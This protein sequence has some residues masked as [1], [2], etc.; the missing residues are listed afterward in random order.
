MATVAEY[1]LNNFLSPLQKFHSSTCIFKIILNHYYILN[2]SNKYSVE[3]CFLF[4][5][6]EFAYNP[7]FCLLAHNAWNIYCLA[8]YGKFANTCPTR[9]LV[10]F[11]QWSCIRSGPFPA[12]LVKDF[13]SPLSCGPLRLYDHAP[14][15]LSDLVLC[16][17]RHVSYCRTLAKLPLLPGNS[18]HLSSIVTSM[19]HHFLRLQTG[20]CHILLKPSFIAVIGF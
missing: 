19:G 5:Y 3:I 1:Q 9:Q 12:S 10:S 16:P 11:S 7:W 4:C 13:A 20:I 8:L 6:I 15:Y 18:A 2:L 17:S 14:A